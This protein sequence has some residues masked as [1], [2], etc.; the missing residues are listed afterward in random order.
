MAAPRIA[1]LIDEG[2]ARL[3]GLPNGRLDAELLFRE[4]SGLT[5]AQILA[6]P[7]QTVNE[8]VADAFGAAIARRE[9]NE[10]V[11][12]ILGRASFWRDEFKV[13]P[14]V[15]IPRPETEVLVESVAR[16]LRQAKAPTFLDIGTGSGC[17]A[18]S[19]LRE[20]P[21]ARAVAVD[22]SAE[23]LD[24]ARENARSLGLVDRVT[25]NRSRWLDAVETRRFDAI[26]SNPP[27]VASSDEASLPLDVRGFEPRL[28]L[29]ADPEDD[30]SSYRAILESV[31]DRVAPG[32]LIAF[33]VGLGQ[34][35]RVLELIRE[36]G[37]QSLDLRDDLQG[38]PRVFLGRRG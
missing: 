4:V 8:R 1:S 7:A 21:A 34:A 16:E 33:E 31:D 24:V 22:V 28:A 14:A 12:Y 29:F 25:F 19:L 13:T 32:G 9:G 11:Q 3:R 36:R 30:L 6:D 18:L 15:L 2:A 5:L 17:I 37:Y 38:I 23:A 20:L 27:Y 35:A 10:P 26:V